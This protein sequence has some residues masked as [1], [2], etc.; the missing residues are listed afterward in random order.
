M[1]WKHKRVSVERGLYKTGDTYWACATAPGERKARWLK[2]GAIGVQE[3]RRLRDEF[4]YKLKI[5]QLPAKIRRLTVRELSEEWFAHLD[6][7]EQ[8]GE[9]RARTVVSY[10]DGVRIHLLPTHGSRDVRSIDADDLVSWHETQRRSGAATWSIRA[11]WMAVRGLLAYAARTGYIVANPCDVLTRRERP[12]PGRPKDRFLTPS[13]IEKLLEHSAGAADL[14]VPMLLFS[15][16]R[17]AE[18]LG[19]TWQDIDFKQHVIRVRYQMSRKGKRTLLKTDAGRREVILMG[20]LARRLRKKR[21]AARFSADQDLI[22][23][24][25]VG[26]TLGY[27]KLLKAFTKSATDARIEGAT[28]HTC[29]HTF[30]SI[31]IDKGADVEFVSDQLGHA[32]TKTTWDIYVHLFRAREH[33]EAARRNLDA[34]FGPMLRAAGDDASDE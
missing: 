24:N 27:T 15:G 22:V 4:A 11:R 26:K 16:L 30:A 18:L 9:L 21:V 29:R 28:P 10:R 7:L 34:A 19:L 13:E 1:A 33:A 3:A 6:E 17:V 14:I 8:A 25:G 32:S 2:L 23:G 12:K 20:E 5:G 31:L